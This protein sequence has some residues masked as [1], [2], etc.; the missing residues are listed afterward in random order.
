MSFEE[1]SLDPRLTAAVQALGYD[2]PT[3]IQSRPFRSCWKAATSSA[4]PRPA[5]ARPRPS[6][7]PS[8]SACT[9]GPRGA[10][11]RADRRAHA[12]AGRADP[13]DDRSCWARDTRLR[14]VADLRRRE[15]AAARSQ[16]LR[17][18]AEIVV[19][20][21]GRLLDH[22]DEPQH[23]PV[24]RR[25]AGAGRSRPHVRHGLPA[26]HPPHPA[27]TCPS[28]ARR[29]SSRPPCPTRS[30]RWPTASSVNPVDGADR[31]DGPGRDGL[32]RALSL[33]PDR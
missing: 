1:F 19:A 13:R 3:P 30:A 16:A 14:S 5:P 2:T 17:R 27:S 9:Q 18:G 32:A 8:C 7:C 12:R 6:C 28:S 10:G 20:C 11:A 4:W 15:Q 22:M 25:S 26:R 23:R 29:S 33:V 21:P 31:H 24:A